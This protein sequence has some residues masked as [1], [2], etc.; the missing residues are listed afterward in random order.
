MN[1]GKDLQEALAFL[2]PGM[3]TYDEW[4]RVGMALKDGGFS[5]DVWDRWSATDADRYHKGECARK[6]ESYKGAAQPVTLKASLNWL[7]STDGPARPVM[8]WIG[9]TP[10][11]RKHCRK[12]RRGCS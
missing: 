6:W 4:V 5:C 11:A 8:S 2:R 9:R 10:S 7:I 1:E 3:L 12:R